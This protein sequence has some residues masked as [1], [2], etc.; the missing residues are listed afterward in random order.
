MSAQKNVAVIIGPTAVGKTAAAMQLHNLLGG[1]SK[2]QIISADSAMIYKG[3]DIGTAKPT[4]EELAVYPHELVSILD[5]AEIY[6]AADFVRDADKQVELAFGADKTPIIVGGTMLYVK[7]FL[8]GIAKLPEADE[9]VRGRLIYELGVKGAKALHRELANIDP[10]AA[11]KIH[12]NNH[13]RLLRA[14]EVVQITGKPISTS[15]TEQGSAAANERLKAKIEVFGMLPTNRHLLHQRIEQRF[16]LM[17]AMGLLNEVALLRERADLHV[18]LPCLRAVGYRQGWRH[19]GGEIDA[20][21]MRETAIA[22]TRQLAKRQLTWMRQ[23]QSLELF[24]TDSPE[25]VAQNIY[26]RIA[27]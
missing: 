20:T 6:S 7:R 14:L 4:P 5:P 26:A 2:A 25:V 27:C 19:L 24:A 22:A 17:L 11:E 13:Q 16:D 1:Q 3:M 18:D 23:W 21:R 12:P 10:L 15:W 8:H 9:A